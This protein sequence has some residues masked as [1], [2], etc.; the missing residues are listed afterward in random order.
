LRLRVFDAGAALHQHFRDAG[1][2]AKVAVDLAVSA[3]G[4]RIF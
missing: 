4:K 1:R 3:F 2:A